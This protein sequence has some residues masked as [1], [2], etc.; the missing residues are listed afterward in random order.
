[1]E[2]LRHEEF[3]PNSLALFP[4]SV[5]YN[6][7][8]LAL[9]DLPFLASAIQRS[10]L[11]KSSQNLRDLAFP[12]FFKPFSLI[13]KLFYQYPRIQVERSIEFVYCG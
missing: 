8:K 2:K 10:R 9:Y 1:M 6:S 11:Q 7:K 4:L 12:V 13:S 5:L 3:A